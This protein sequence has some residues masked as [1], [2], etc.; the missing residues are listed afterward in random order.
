MKRAIPP[1]EEKFSVAPPEEKIVLP[2]TKSR[3]LWIGDIPTDEPSDITQ[4]IEEE[5]RILS[6]EFHDFGEVHI[7]ET[8]GIAATIDAFVTIHFTLDQEAKI[9]EA[10]EHFKVFGLTI[11]VC[12]TANFNEL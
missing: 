3:K 6:T 11:Q 1:P 4:C 12:T 7:I 2:E 10:I 8:S 5:F 9:N